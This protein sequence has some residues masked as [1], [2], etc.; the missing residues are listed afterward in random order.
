METLVANQVTIRLCDT[1]GKNFYLAKADPS[2]PTDD[3]EESKEEQEPAK[4]ITV[5]ITVVFN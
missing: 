5:P 2:A 1:D 3:Q 4:P